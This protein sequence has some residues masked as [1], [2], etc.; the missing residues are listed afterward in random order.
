MDLMTLIEAS[1]YLGVAEVTLR[2][3]IEKG[4]KVPHKRIGR[5][6]RFSKVDLDNWV[7]SGE[8]SK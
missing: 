2:K 5:F 1:K 3:W 4:K 6:Y 8:A 7:N